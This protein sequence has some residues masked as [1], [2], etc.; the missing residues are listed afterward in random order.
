MAKVYVSRID[1]QKYV[2]EYNRFSQLI[3]WAKRVIQGREQYAEAQIAR[4]TG[5]IL[6]FRQGI[7]VSPPGLA[8]EGIAALILFAAQ[9]P[10]VVIEELRRGDVL[11]IPQ[12]K[13][14]IAVEGRWDKES[15]KW[16]YR[17]SPPAEAPTGSASNKA[18]SNKASTEASVGA[19]ARVKHAR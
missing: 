14:V 6:A 4:L 9:D 10:E 7:P 16:I 12:G 15:S 5:A 1:S 17:F 3:S 18:S 8:P 2:A 11:V 13:V 19:R